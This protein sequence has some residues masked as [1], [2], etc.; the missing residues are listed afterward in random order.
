[1]IGLHNFQ[2]I[3]CLELE[4][5]YKPRARLGNFMREFLELVVDGPPD[6]RRLA[7]LRYFRWSDAFFEEAYDVDASVVRAA[8]VAA[9][10][11][12][13]AWVAQRHR[14]MGVAYVA[15]YPG[16]GVGDRGG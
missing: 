1:M 2:C 16:T 5:Q 6:L 11:W 15:D 9:P 4:T 3:R 14:R 13:A 10:F 8:E 12:V 7:L